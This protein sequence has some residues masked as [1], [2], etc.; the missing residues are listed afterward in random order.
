MAIYLNTYE[1]WQAY[2]GPEEGGWWY[3]CG[4]P[5]QSIKISDED[6][7]TLVDKR[8]NRHSV[9]SQR[10]EKFCKLYREQE[11]GEYRN[12]L[13]ILIDVIEQ[14]I[15]NLYEIGRLPELNRMADAV[16]KNFGETNQI[17]P[18]LTET[19]GYGFVICS[20]DEEDPTPTAYYGDQKYETNVESDFAVPFPQERPRYE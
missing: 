5:V 16:N 17:V 12:R 14:R 15:S 7:Q 1:T 6:L 4:K 10:W 18:K 11:D 9:L 19:G 8:D 2:G 3:E 13:D 20:P